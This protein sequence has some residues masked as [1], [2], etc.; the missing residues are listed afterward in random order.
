MSKWHYWHNRFLHKESKIR[1]EK[2]V[3]L[4]ILTH[5]V[6]SKPDTVE[7]KQIVHAAKIQTPKKNTKSE[8]K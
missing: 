6:E 8:K 3:V 4:P 7:T 2:A 1:T 5:E